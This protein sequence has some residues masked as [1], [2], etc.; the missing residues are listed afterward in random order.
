MMDKRDN[1]NLRVRTLITLLLIC[2]LIIGQKKQVCFSFDDLP[3]VTYYIHD[4]TFTRNLFDKLASTL[5]NNR[6]P[7]IGF[8]NEM[9]LCDKEKLVKSQV[10]L[11]FYW[12]NNGLDLGNHTFS[13]L[14]Y[15][16]IPF[17]IF[18]Q[19]IL[20]G[21]LVTGE[22][23]KGANRKLKYF[24]YPYLHAGNSKARSDSLI[25]FLSDHGYI[26]APVTF[27]NDDYLFAAAYEKCMK[28]VDSNLMSQ[29]GHDYI[30][31]T[32][33]KL[34]YYQKQTQN[35]FGRDIRHILLLHPSF[36]NACYLDSLILLF[37][38]NDYD[39]ISLDEALKDKVYK[40]EITRFGNWG[41]SWI[42]R[43]ALSQGKKGDFFKDEPAV[44][45]YIQKMSKD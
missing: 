12:V 30:T 15:N 25:N 1:I 27:D 40:A 11:L 18:T 21:G 17:P 45:N 5:R 41:I 38:K 44:P 20:K 28:G 42:D 4:T 7:A 26:A 43:W 35:L 39:F 32:E 9:K 13:H 36:L 19:D 3:F 8:V 31:Y 2:Q 22:I 6:I 10:D 34:K 33:R 37:R 23:L 29:I 16:T 14:D 24:R